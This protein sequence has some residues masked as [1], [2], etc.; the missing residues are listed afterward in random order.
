MYLNYHDSGK[1]STLDLVDIEMTTDELKKKYLEFFEGKGHA[2]IPSAS[3][4][5]ENDPTVLFTTAGMHPLT[6]YLLGEEHPLGKRIVNVQKCL[7][8][9]DIDEVGD[10]THVTFFEMLGNWSLGDYWKKESISW[11]Y[12][13]LTKELNIPVEKLAVTCFEGDKEI[14]KDIESAE[15]W[16]SLGIDKSRIFFLGK[17]DNWWGPVGNTGPCGPDTEIYFW[18]GD[19]EPILLESSEGS[20]GWV[21]IWNNVFMEYEKTSDGIY[22]PLKQKNVDTG[23]GVERTVAVL[24]GFKDV[25]KIDGLSDIFDKVSSLSTSR[26]EKSM[27]ILTDHIRASVFILGD[28]RC[29]S[30][31]NTDQGYVLRKLIRKSVREGRKLGIPSPFLVELSKIVVDKY[32]TYYPELK[33]NQGFIEKYLGLEEE[34]FG[35][36][37]KV[38]Q[39][40]SF[41][42][43]D[44]IDNFEEKVEVFGLPVPLLSKESF[45][46]YQSHGYPV[47]MFIE[48]LKERKN[49]NDNNLKE[50][51]GDVEKLICCHQDISR[52]GAEKKFKGGLSDNSDDVVKYHTATHLLNKALRDVVGSHVKQIGSNIT[53]ERLRFDFPNNSK[54]TEEEILEV[55]K[56]VN[57][58][59]DQN[60]EV[61]STVLPKGDAVSC[62]AIHLEGEQYPEQVKVYF[63]GASLESNVSMEFCGG[64]HVKSTGEI[65]HIEIYK[66]DKI[67]DGKMRI[68]A[69]FK[70]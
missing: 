4:V 1:I 3:I 47:D 21:E 57:D 29:I 18:T 24:N 52:K 25:Y 19:G 53:S 32:G 14:P 68:Y 54:L 59:I 34:K 36:I 63:I 55:E 7:R 31:S 64:P 22:V 66:Q 49:I 26:N 5:P 39:K 62:G 38:G 51:S 70:K 46:L 65:G 50:I 13:F 23:M 20:G 27:R 61:N 2:I 40:E 45:D 17:K 16:E 58:I 11:S 33:S 9:D 10:N 42:R 6:P 41:K 48:D 69:R 28:Q 30:P 60:I 15:I 12:E 56:K 35:N 37:L 67:G 8:T 44:S 43:I